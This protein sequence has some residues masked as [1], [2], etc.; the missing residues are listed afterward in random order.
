MMQ[1]EKY[2]DIDIKG[3]QPHHSTHFCTFMQW[4]LERL[5]QREFRRRCRRCSGLSYLD[6]MQNRSLMGAVCT[7][8]GCQKEG[9]GTLS[10]PSSVPLIMSLLTNVLAN[11]GTPIMCYTVVVHTGVM[12]NHSIQLHEGQDLKTENVVCYASEMHIHLRA[13]QN[14]EHGHCLISFYRS[15]C[16][17]GSKQILP[18]VPPG[19]LIFG[20]LSQSCISLQEPQEPLI[21]LSVYYGQYQV[22][23]ALLQGIIGIYIFTHLYPYTKPPSILGSVHGA[24]SCKQEKQIVLHQVSCSVKQQLGP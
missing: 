15:T 8:S 23:S 21:I 12:N 22:Y 4:T 7:S 20:E 14:R 18:H 19:F 11:F 10:T 6:E 9:V 24:I 16:L 13:M 2:L 5:P 1:R 17:P 3:T